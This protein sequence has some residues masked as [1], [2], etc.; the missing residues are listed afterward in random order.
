M[1]FDV[2]SPELASR[3]TAVDATPGLWSATTLW[4][5]QR[6]KRTNADVWAKIAG[7]SSRSLLCRESQLFLRARLPNSG[8]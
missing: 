4:S 3:A 2:V 7:A 1:R 8:V 5:R 6:D